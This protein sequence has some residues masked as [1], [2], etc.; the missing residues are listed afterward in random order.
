MIAAYAA[1]V[2]AMCTGSIALG[3]PVF[4][5]LGDLPG[6]N[7][8]SQAEAV[9]GDGL[10]VVGGSISDQGWEAFVWRAGQGMTGLGDLGGGEFESRAFGVSGDG[11][12][13]CG[14]GVTERGAAAFRWTAQ[15]GLEALAEPIGAVVG[16]SMAQ[17]VSAGEGQRTVQAVLEAAGVDLK[18]WTLRWATGVSADG[19]VICGNGINP[20]GN[21]EAWVVDLTGNMI[22]EAGAMAAVPSFEDWREY[23]FTH[24]YADFH[25]HNDEA[26]IAE[27]EERFSRVPPRVL[28]EYLIRLFEDSR[29]LRETYTAQQLA[30][31]TW[32][33]FGLGSE[34][35]HEV[36]DPGVPAELQARVYRAMPTMYLEVYDRLCNDQGRS[37]E[38]LS[39]AAALDIAVY[40]IWDMDCVEGAVMFP[41]NSP[42]L[43]EPGFGVL[44][45]VLDRCSTGACLKGALHALGHLEMYHPERVRTMVDGFLERRRDRLPAWVVEYA[46]EAREGAVQ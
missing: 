2:V 5:G 20:E 12:I 32:F 16:N 17:A 9:S 44:Q 6:G 7:F 22:K 37:S 36:R 26:G 11:S 13:V 23:C 45:T 19:T 1:S 3:Q 14:R 25:G 24:G 18:G 34:Y 33:I 40:M 38:D 39:D 21:D 4:F 8:G 27:R 29:F 31:G 35:F 43:V 28:A 15:G 30:D 42:H 10:T 46:L 41:E